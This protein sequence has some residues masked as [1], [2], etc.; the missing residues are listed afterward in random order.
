LGN[1]E[2]R[3]YTASYKTYRANFTPEQWAYYHSIL[4]GR[5]GP[6][7]EAEAVDVVCRDIPPA[8]EIPRGE[9]AAASQRS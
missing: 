9:A 4:R 7:L 1:G 8:R 6:Q 2:G 5:T 3:K